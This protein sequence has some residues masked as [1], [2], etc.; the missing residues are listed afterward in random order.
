MAKSNHSELTKRSS[1][2]FACSILQPSSPNSSVSEGSAFSKTKG[3]QNIE[4][5]GARLGAVLKSLLRQPDMQSNSM[6]AALNALFLARASHTAPKS[7]QPTC[8]CLSLLTIFSVYSFRFPFSYYLST[9]SSICQA[10][11]FT[12]NSDSDSNGILSS[13][14]N[15]MY[16]LR[17]F[18]T[19]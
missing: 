8:C 10:C 9:T 14:S 6:R 5:Y 11:V 1:N 15:R 19:Y 18:M 13:Y 12:K 7:Y 17:F 3:V 2:F 4:S 16:T